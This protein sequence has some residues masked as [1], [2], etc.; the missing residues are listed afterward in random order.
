[1]SATIISG[2][3]AVNF[4]AQPALK[5]NL[6]RTLENVPRLRSGASHKFDR[7]FCEEQTCCEKVHAQ[8]PSAILEELDDDKFFLA[9]SPAM[10]EIHRQVMLLRGF[11][12]SVLIDGESGTGKEIIA[13]LIHKHSRGPKQNFVNVNCAALPME[14]LE[15]EL[16]GH[17]KGAFTGAVNDRPGR[18]EQANG[19]TILLDE[20]GEISA[21]MQAK[22]LHVLQDGQFT[23]L[24]DRQATRVD[25][26][27]LAATN[28]CIEKAL[29]A[30]T[31]RED[32]YYRLSTFTIHVPPLRERT[33]EIP[34]LVRE[35]IARASLGKSTGMTQFSR[36]LMELLPH[37]RWPGN[38]RELRNFVYRTLIVQ[39]EQSAIR[40]LEMKISPGL[41]MKRSSS[42][43]NQFSRGAP[44]LTV[45]HDMRG[46]TEARMI[47]EAL[48]ANGWNRR[49]T[50]RYLDIS[51]RSLLYK[52]QQ[53]GLTPQACCQS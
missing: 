14:L 24:G 39:D 28:I 10:V 43:H 48:Q 1:M 5:R 19:G 20:I 51:Y 12:V 23:R 21:P 2:F 8:E 17:V 31:L 49:N 13:Q 15:S 18:F 40:E 50:A 16:F 9:L 35:M 29:S 33:E 45:V 22:L 53:Y 32:L 44:M 27:V 7:T 25:V 46:R 41:R 47:G 38:L 11:N 52:I 30:K 37:H 3:E 6:D 26:Q 34:H 4:L 42:E 36:E